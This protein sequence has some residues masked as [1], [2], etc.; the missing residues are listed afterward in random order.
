MSTADDDPLV[1]AVPRSAA[2]QLERVFAAGLLAV[3]RAEGGRPTPEAARV[4]RELHAA[5]HGHRPLTPA[6][7]VGSGELP[8]PTVELTVDEVALAM[9]CRP[10]WVR[11]LAESGR[12]RGRRVN[13]RFWLIDATSV[14]EYRFGR[15]SGQSGPAQAEQG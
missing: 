14:D 13:P 3:S 12:L 4:L 10:R 15:T 7:D 8:T 1:L 11:T 2:R 5:A 9:G 6:A